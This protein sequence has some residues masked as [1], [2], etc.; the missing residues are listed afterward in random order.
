MRSDGAGASYRDVIYEPYESRNI[1]FIY[2]ES[3]AIVN[4][5]TPLMT[6][7]ES[8][9]QIIDGLCCLLN[10]GIPGVLSRHY[11]VI[12]PMLCRPLIIMYSRLQ[13][14]R[15]HVNLHLVG[16]LTRHEKYICRYVPR[17]A[18]RSAYIPNPCVRTLYIKLQLCI[19]GYL[20]SGYVPLR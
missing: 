12:S 5:Y 2:K 3:C 1:L 16:P 7:G 8:G 11:S 17:Y 9:G 20:I 15:E 6:D 13:F 4:W 14:P 10:P 18:A 19:I